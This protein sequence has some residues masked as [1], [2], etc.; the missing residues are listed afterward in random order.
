M[1]TTVGSHPASGWDCPAKAQ[2]LWAA[3][4][5][6]QFSSPDPANIQLQ[7]GAELPNGGGA[8][9]GI[10]AID[11]FELAW[12]ALQSLPERLGISG[13]PAAIGEIG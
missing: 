4:A 2:P 13:E 10:E 6:D 12:L 9:R 5:F 8:L 1:S 3:A 11:P 7:I